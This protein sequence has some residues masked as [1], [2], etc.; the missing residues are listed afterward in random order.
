LFQ[1]QDFASEPTFFQPLSTLLCGATDKARQ[2]KN[3]DLNLDALKQLG[4]TYILSGAEIINAPEIH[5]D[6]LRVFDHP[7][8]AWRIY[9]YRVP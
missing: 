2:I 7:A 4:G 8:S 5:L 6:L 9:L 1:Q 3:L